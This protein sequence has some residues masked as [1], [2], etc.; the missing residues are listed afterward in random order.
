MVQIFQRIAKWLNGEKTISELAKHI[1]CVF[2]D[3]S[4]EQAFLDLVFSH[5]S[6]YD[7]S[8]QTHKNDNFSDD[9][10][11]IN[12]CTTMSLTSPEHLQL[13]SQRVDAYFYIYRRITEYIQLAKGYNYQPNELQRQLFEQ[14]CSVFNSTKGSQ[15]NLCVS[16]KDIIKRMNIQVHLMSI[17][18]IK[19]VPTLNTFLVLCKLSFQSS[20]LVDEHDRLQWIDVLSKIKQWRIPLT[21][22]FSNYIE[23]KQAFEQFPLDMQAFI[24]LIRMMHPQKNTQTSTFELFQDMLNILNLDPKE[25]FYQ[26]QSVFANHLTGE[27]YTISH[28]ASL[29]CML[30]TRD[31]KL[32]DKYLTIYSS[33]VPTDTIWTMFLALSKIGDINGIIQKY[34]IL[35]LTQRIENISTEDF[36]RFN[37]LAKDSLIQI[38]D[39]KRPPILKIFET[40]LYAFLNKQL[41]DDQYSHKFTESHLKEFLNTSLDLSVSHSLENPSCLLIIRHLLFKLDRQTVN[42]FEKLK[43]L[44][45]RLN[46]LNEISCETNDPALIIQDDW[47]IEYIFHI[48]HDWL[49]L[50]KHDYQ[51]LC[52]IHH[53]NK[54]SIYIWSKL[55]NL[56]ILKSQTTKPNEI[57]G[58]LNEWLVKVNHDSSNV[59]N[60]LTIIFV[61]NT[62]EVVINK[63][64]TSALLLS[65]IESILQYILRIRDDAPPHLIDTK[66][67]DNFVDNV[68]QSIK[69]V[70]L[71][72]GKESV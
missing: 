71:L 33:N 62:F 18:E 44:F 12:H 54:W 25:F 19:D 61:R 4:K 35:I 26:F 13:F 23:Y 34:L 1:G 57:L 41:H 65:N 6:N 46:N 30:S 42:K 68:K 11:F 69:D 31:E 3:N 7:E 21:D 53:N 55:V 59:N 50:T 43:R 40:V 28:I 9:I 17:K 2:D 60:I 14:L 22:F 32:F 56:S 64:I 29:L 8:N 47:L 70:L 51:S 37:R 15:P 49:S 72:N 45:K 10:E 39:E 36:K 48:P 24:Y 38:N 20:L 58:K 5:F 66:A 27:F 67:V 52:E 16:N 63:Q